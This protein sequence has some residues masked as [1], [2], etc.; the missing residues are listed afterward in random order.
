MVNN[1]GYREL[2]LNKYNFTVRHHNRTNHHQLM[3]MLSHCRETCRNYL[4][5]IPDTELPEELVKLGRYEDK[6][7]DVFGV[8]LDI[9]DLCK[10]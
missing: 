9:C 4:K 10:S 7:M 3:F 6:I 8:D 5:D 2:F 1:E